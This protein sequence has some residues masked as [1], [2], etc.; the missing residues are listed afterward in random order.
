MRGLLESTKIR[1]RQG[2]VFRQG[3]EPDQ[4]GSPSK[5]YDGVFNQSK[6]AYSSWV[7]CS[8]TVL[9]CML[10]FLCKITGCNI[11]KEKL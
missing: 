3:C 6:M 8:G 1:N 7:D 11:I 10:F 5:M 4:T 2:A 9:V